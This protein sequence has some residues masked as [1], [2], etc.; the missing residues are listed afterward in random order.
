MSELHQFFETLKQPEYVH[1]LLNPLPVYGTAM[2]VLGLLLALAL[3]NRP[4]QIVALVLIAVGCFS[5]W[6]VSEYGED[7]AYR[8]QTMSNTDEPWL[9]EHA[10]RADDAAWFFYV[11]GAL[12]VAGIVAGWKSPKIATW[13]SVAALVAG[14][15]CLALGG[16]IAH[17][18]GQIRHS[19]FR[20][21]PPPAREHEHEH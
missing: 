4:A 7:A 11:T 21:G 14:M 17:A 12:A 13:L 3:R 2:G 18:G 9:H 8:V 15:V 1:V 6:P 10:E 20:D 16:W 5:V 19:E